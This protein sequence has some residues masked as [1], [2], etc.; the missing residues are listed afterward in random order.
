[1]DLFESTDTEVREELLLPGASVLR[2]FA[3]SRVEPLMIAI[4]EVLRLAPLRNMITPGGSTM[5]VEMSNCGA[6]GWVSDR[7]GYRYAALDPLSSRPWPV[8]PEA[9]ARLAV[10][11]AASA[12]FPGFKADACLINRYCPGA[13]MGL[14]QDR[15][16]QDFEAP[17]VS[18]SLGLPAAFLFGGKVRSD[19]P[20]SVPLAHGDVVVWGRSAR[21]NFHG[22]RPLKVGEHALTG[23]YRYNLTLRKAGA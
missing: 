11:A 19:R 15:D 7:H 8:L 17:I 10:E 9:F 18:V 16:E 1:M 20:L 5:S 21:Q 12:G 4:E 14:H 6:L 2:N 13:R 22:V 3:L 23:S